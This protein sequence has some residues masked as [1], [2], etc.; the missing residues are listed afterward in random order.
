MS[1]T[2]ALEIIKAN[3]PSILRFTH[4]LD[5]PGY[6]LLLIGA[7]IDD[8]RIAFRDASLFVDEFINDVYIEVTPSTY[9][10]ALDHIINSALS[11]NAL[12]ALAAKVNTKDFVKVDTFLT[13]AITPSSEVV[14]ALL[15]LFNERQNL[16]WLN[17]YTP[18]IGPVA[19]KYG[20]SWLDSDPEGIVT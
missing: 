5:N 11:F 19:G 12:A 8:G 18:N 9:N 16:A 4:Y 17:E 6:R 10:E 20:D 13:R 3:A 15:T 7:V 1:T 14:A 2:D